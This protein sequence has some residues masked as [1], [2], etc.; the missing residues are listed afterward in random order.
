MAEPVS[1]CECGCG[2]AAGVWTYTN[3]SLG[4][5]KGQPK[6]F[7][8]LHSKIINKPVDALKI[9]TKLCGCG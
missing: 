6:R 4:I 9:P 5:I 2:E 7:L 3:N 1:L 8:G